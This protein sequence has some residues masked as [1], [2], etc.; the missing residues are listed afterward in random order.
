M[1]TFEVVGWY[2]VSKKVIRTVVAE[3]EDEAIDKAIWD[4]YIDE[5]EID[6][7]YGGFEIEDVSEGTE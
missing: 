2:D 7:D 3:N 6:E 4:N 1:K 5:V